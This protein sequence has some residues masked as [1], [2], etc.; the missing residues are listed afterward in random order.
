MGAL[1]GLI[2]DFLIEEYFEAY[3][4]V[5]EGKMTSCQSNRNV[6]AKVISCS[7][8]PLLIPWRV[9]NLESQNTLV[10]VSEHLVNRSYISSENSP[11]AQRFE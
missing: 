1:L 10:E 8:D 5:K 6:L 11:L 7:F 2:S 9:F 3:V 4:F